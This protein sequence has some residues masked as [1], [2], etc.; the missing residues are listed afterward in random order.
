VLTA[1][2]VALLGVVLISGLGSGSA[3]GDDPLRGVVYALLTALAYAGFLLVIREAGRGLRTPAE[4]MLDAT[5]SCALAVAIVGAALGELDL[6]PDWEASGWLLTLAVSGQVVGYLAIAASLPRLPAL[7]ASILLLVQ[8]VLSVMLAAAIVDERPS[9]LQIT[10]VLLV[11]AGIVI[12]T[13]GGRR[14]QE[15]AVPAEA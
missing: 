13:T 10:G 11:V 14:E 12:A 4:I 7:V 3:Y 1:V 9:P 5:A 15:A 8:P 2:P 6:T